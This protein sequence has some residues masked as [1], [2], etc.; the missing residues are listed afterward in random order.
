MNRRE[1]ITLVGGAAAWS[2]AGRAQQPANIARIGIIDNAA[3]WDPFRQAL[4][5]L[6]YVEG[7]NI[8]FEYRFAEG[9]PA[10][11]TAAAT[12]LARLPGRRYRHHRHASVPCSQ[13]GDRDGP[14]CHH[15]DW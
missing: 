4:R 14:H 6:G 9:V 10:R 13:A 5:D 12:E 1:F 15:W 11:L 8:K 3:M 2:L 7:Q